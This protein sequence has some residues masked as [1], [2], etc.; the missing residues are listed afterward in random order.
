MVWG[1]HLGWNLF[2]DGVFGM[3]NSGIT[4]LPSWIQPNINGPEWIT[5]GSIGIEMSVIATVLSLI[6]GLI[7]IKKAIEKKQIVAPVWKK[8]S[9]G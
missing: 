9:R 4:D 1:I 7:I 6:V 2:Q 5:G 8:N 3:P